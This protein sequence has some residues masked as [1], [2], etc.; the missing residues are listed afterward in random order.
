MVSGVC[1]STLAFFVLQALGLRV[2]GEA[3]TGTIRSQALPCP[4]QPCPGIIELSWSFV[5]SQHV[6]PKMLPSRYVLPEVFVE[7]EFDFGSC[8]IVRGCA[9]VRTSPAYSAFG[10]A[11]KLLPDV[12]GAYSVR[13]Q[14]SICGV[15][16]SAP[17]PL[18]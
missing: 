9:R 7:F 3:L 18:L 15:L 6:P 4:P 5:A 8:V 11:K 10:C 12:V 16:C 13:M 14:R 17:R 1:T 2:Q